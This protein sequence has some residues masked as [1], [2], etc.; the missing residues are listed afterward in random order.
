MI[1]NVTE[2]TS[3]PGYVVVANIITAAPLTVRDMD[4]SVSHQTVCRMDAAS[5]RTWMYSQRV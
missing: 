3:A 1:N 5:E 4:W 2:I